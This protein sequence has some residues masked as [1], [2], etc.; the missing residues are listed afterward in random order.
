MAKPYIIDITNGEG[1]KQVLN[2][3]YTVTASVTGY[4]NSSILPA[5]VTIS[6]SAASY[7]FTIA[8]TGTLTLHVTED[9]TENGTPV[10]G[11]TFVRCDA[12]GNTYGTEITTNDQGNAIFQYVPFAETSA[13]LIYYKQ[14]ASDGEHQFDNTLKN[15]SL[16]EN[17]KTIQ[18]A[19]PSPATKT[20]TLKD[21]NY[22]GLKIQTGQITLN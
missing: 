13:P 4:D 7:D 14:T 17:T 15:T 3:D 5:N 21:A 20:F 18:V 6:D 9:G 8:S 12:D 2:G 10:V 16:T 1:S 19:N 11:A 22:S